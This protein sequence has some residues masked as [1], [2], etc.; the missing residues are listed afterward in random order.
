MGVRDGSRACNSIQQHE[1]KQRKGNYVANIDP[2]KNLFSKSCSLP[3]DITDLSS[4][5]RGLDLQQLDKDVI[6]T[7]GDNTKRKI[8]SHRRSVSF[9]SAEII[10][11]EPT[12]HTAT[13]ASYGV[14]IGLSHKV[15]CRA[16]YRIDI[17]EDQRF[18][19]RIDRQEYM[20]RG[21]LEPQERIDILQ[22]CGVEI[23]LL[24]ALSFDE[25]WSPENVDSVYQQELAD[26]PLLEYD[27]AAS[28]EDDEYYYREEVAHEFSGEWAHEVLVELDKKST[29]ASTHELVNQSTH[30]LVDE[31]THE[32]VNQSTHEFVDESTHESENELNARCQ[33]D[34][35]SLVRTPPHF[36]ITDRH[37]ESSCRDYGIHYV[38]SWYHSYNLSVE[39]D[40]LLVL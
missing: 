31:S 40:L 24:K 16:H 11:F 19:N 22:N 28:S 20:E 13:V 1:P 37:M 32:L 26:I 4:E 15:R 21:Y 8:R 38:N 18:E 2:K 10:E 3:A 5:E 30:E 14:T 36:G 17:W 33:S 35:R 12:F 25:D 39:T 23:G 29:H 7:H 9:T 27:E 6:I 34:D